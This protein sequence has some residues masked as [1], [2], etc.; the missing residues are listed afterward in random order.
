MYW[1]IPANPKFYDYFKEFKDNGFI[2]WHQ[3]GNYSI[4]DIVFIYSGSPY[5]RITFKTIVEKVN[6]LK[7]NAFDDE[8]YHYENSPLKTYTKYI[9]LR[10][11]SSYNTDKLSLYNLQQHGLKSAPQCKI[12]LKENLLEYILNE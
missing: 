4:G 5:K 11:L 12:K 3:I 10:L 8:V 2:D 1:L 7:D 6:I 9:R